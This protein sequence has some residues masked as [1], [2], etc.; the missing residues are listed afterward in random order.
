MTFLCGIYSTL[1]RG[2]SEDSLM[3]RLDNVRN[4]ANT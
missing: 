1:T 3:E 4:K 2:G